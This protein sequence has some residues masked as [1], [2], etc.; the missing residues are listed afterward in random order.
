MNALSGLSH[1]QDFQLRL[2]GSFWGMQSPLLHLDR[3]SGLKKISLVSIRCI[4]L[5][6]RIIGRLA[7][8]IAKCPHL[9]ALQIDIKYNSYTQ[10]EVSQRT[11]TLHDLL[12]KV[13]QDRPLRLNHLELHGICIHV[14]SFILP[15]LHSLTSLDLMYIPTISPTDPDA[16]FIRQSH[17]HAFMPTNIYA[18]LKRE[19]IYLKQ[20]AVNVMDD[21]IF[22]Y[23]C[24][25]SGLEILDLCFIYFN[26]AEV[27]DAFAN[28]F[29]KSVLPKHVDSIQVLKI[30]PGHEGRWCYNPEDAS[31]AAVLSQCN[32]LRI[33]SVALSST[34]IQMHSEPNDLAS[35]HH[36]PHQSSPSPYEYGDCI[37]DAVCFDDHLT[38]FRRLRNTTLDIIS[39]PLVVQS[40]QSLPARYLFSN[41]RI[42]SRLLAEHWCA[43][44]R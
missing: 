7:E 14:D 26:S 20:L 19:K 2:D 29:Y 27:S 24:S 30:R 11:L 18:M 33:L 41:P 17:E 22:E 8:A 23:L 15:H 5:R 34:P 25:Y 21:I 16:A 28:R 35:F 40:T 13:P 38:V 44:A 1:L 10:E 9:L 37:K 3:L 6:S 39:D 12:R 4:N 42:R 36:L 43:C 31:Q 32:K